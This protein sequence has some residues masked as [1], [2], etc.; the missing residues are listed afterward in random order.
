MEHVIPFYLFFCVSGGI[1]AL[2]LLFIVYR[3]NPRKDLLYF[4]LFF[5]AMT[6]DIIIDLVLM[7]RAI[8]IT[9]VLSL[10]DYLLT[11]ISV[12]FSVIMFSAFPAA[13][14]RIMEVSKEKW[15]NLILIIINIVLN[16]IQYFPAGSSYNIQTGT[17][18]LGPLFAVTGISQLVIII[19]CVFL[20]LTGFRKIKENSVRRLL[21]FCGLLTLLFTP[22]FFHDITYSIGRSYFD[23][24]PIEV[25]FF[26]LYYFLLA[27]LV[28]VY[29]GRYFIAITQLEKSVRTSEEFLFEF[30]QKHGLTEREKEVVPLI[31][32]G[33]GNKQI[34]GKLC[35]ST[36]TVDNHIYN[37]YRKLEINS[38]F[39]LLAMC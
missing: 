35:I 20:L 29:S 15:R 8:N 17:L 34:A 28:I 2:V 27:V 5:A 1:A 30:S 33:M 6:V 3:K 13:L 26:P 12:P 21:M 11:L 16:S 31:V 18:T 22:G 7:Y 39:E 37:L 38:R 9:S 24:F 19:Y 36:K 14:H 32:E 10:G 4:Y 23:I 25:I